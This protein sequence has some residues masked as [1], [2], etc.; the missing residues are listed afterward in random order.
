MNEK[1]ISASLLGLDLFGSLLFVIGAVGQFGGE[2]SLLPDSW[3]FP[4]VHWV[5]MTAGVAMILPYM[6]HVIRKGRRGDETA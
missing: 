3:V 2:G 5:L 6:M 4:G 1:T